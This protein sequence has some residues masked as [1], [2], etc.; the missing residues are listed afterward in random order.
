MSSR[1][2]LRGAALFVPALP[3]G[4]CSGSRDDSSGSA[5]GSSG[6]SGAF[7]V[8]VGTAFGDVRVAAAPKRVVALGWGD[9]E[10]ALALGVQPVGASDWLA[11]GG[12]GVGPWA[13]GLY[14]AAPTIIDTLQP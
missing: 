11:F 10:T 9:A 4:G 13:A 6:S 8:T 1:I 3:A 12:E 2:A 14:D 7:P 5:G